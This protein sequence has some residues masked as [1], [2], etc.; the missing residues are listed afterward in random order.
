M[1]PESR[2]KKSIRVNPS[3]LTVS[4]LCFG[5][6]PNVSREI[7]LFVLMIYF[8]HKGHRLEN[9]I[10]ETVCFHFLTA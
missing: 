4:T 10:R 5:G 7:Y 9:N 3:F 8:Q 1:A 2:R 6:S